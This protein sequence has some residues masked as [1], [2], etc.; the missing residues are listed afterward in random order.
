MNTVSL[1]RIAA[2]TLLATG[3]LA[4]AACADWSATP[5]R[6]DRN[7]GHA[8]GNMVTQQVYNPG[9]AQHPAA[10]APDGIEGMK[11]EGALEVYRSDT[12]KPADVEKKTSLGV[13][14]RTGSSGSSR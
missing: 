3:L 12:G 4:L 13:I 1:P 8:V 9:K 14:G 10:K 6:I 7:F 5:A 11:A 2:R